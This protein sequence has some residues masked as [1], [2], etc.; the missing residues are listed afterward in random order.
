M[1]NEYDLS[2]FKSLKKMFQQLTDHE[3]ADLLALAWFTREKI[4][5]W[6]AVYEYARTMISSADDN[7][8]IGLASC[9]LA[10]FRPMGRKTS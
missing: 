2:S 6:P 10:G 1:Q 7:Y 9:W 3:R 4:A 8:Q 5:N